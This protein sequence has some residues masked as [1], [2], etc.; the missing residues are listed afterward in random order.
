LVTISISRKALPKLY[1]TKAEILKEMFRQPNVSRGHSHAQWK[2]QGAYLIIAAR[3]LGLDCG[4]MSGFDNIV[5]TKRFLRALASNQTSSVRSATGGE[6]HP[7][8]R[9]PRLAFEEAWA[10]CLTGPVEGAA[11]VHHFEPPVTLDVGPQLHAIPG[12]F[13]EP[14]NRMPTLA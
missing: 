2:L 8:P 11:R 12:S 5:L 3:A 9:N 1:P 4:P 10:I 13:S 14:S 6:G 7:I